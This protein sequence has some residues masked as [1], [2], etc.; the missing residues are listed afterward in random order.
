VSVLAALSDKIDT[1]VA[2]FAIGEKPTGSRDPYALRR[3]AQGVIRII[4]ENRLRV[5][6]AEAFALARSGTGIPAA[7]DLTE[8]QVVVDELLTFVTDRLKVDLRDQGVRHDLI[9]AAFAQFGMMGV[10]YT[11]R[12]ED[13]LVRLLARVRALDAFL[14]SEDGA[15]LLT[16]YRRAV[17]IVRI[18]DEKE[19]R[20]RSIDHDLTLLREPEEVALSDGLDKIGNRA[21]GLARKERFEEA[22]AELARLRRPVDEFFEKVTVNT[23]DAVLRE[24]RLRLLARIRA[25]M[26]QVADFSLIEG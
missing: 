25:T 8:I 13:D 9:D 20:Y 1:L 11:G 15:G 2:F 12:N 5:P 21:A 17:N 19:G 4:L 26:N 23:D 24:N 3:A 7:V 18:E 14:G 10:Q 6:L 22:M 16:A